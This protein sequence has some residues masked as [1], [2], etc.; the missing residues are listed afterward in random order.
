M[1]GSDRLGVLVR[2][3]SAGVNVCLILLYRDTDLAG[4]F[5]TSRFGYI[6][7]LLRLCAVVG[8]WDFSKHSLLVLVMELCKIGSCM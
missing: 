6:V 7:L 4:Y 8:L 5:K 1:W 3:I 2:M